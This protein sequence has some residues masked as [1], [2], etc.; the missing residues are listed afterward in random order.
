VVDNVPII[1]ETL[2]N[3]LLTRIAKQF[4]NGG[5]PYPEQNVVL[6]WDSATG[7]TKG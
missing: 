2:E 7:K 4:T 5:C 3:K 6:P 1:D